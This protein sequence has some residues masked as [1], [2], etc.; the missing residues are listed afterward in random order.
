MTGPVQFAQFDEC[1]QAEHTNICLE[2]GTWPSARVKRALRGEHWTWRRGADA[3]RT[4]TAR[5][6]L[7]AAF[8]PDDAYWK[9]VIWQQGHEAFVQALAGLQGVPV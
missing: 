4:A 2:F 3:A 7:K 6:D 9:R 8:Y 5:A 1:P